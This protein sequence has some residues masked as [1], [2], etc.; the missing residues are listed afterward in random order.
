VK[1]LKLRIVGRLDS[2]TK[3][4]YENVNFVIKR[5]TN[6]ITSSTCYAFA[7]LLSCLKNLFLM[8]KRNMLIKLSAVFDMHIDS[9]K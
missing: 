9:T 6:E 5:A 2:Q 1:G 3:Y 7:A 4:V 8:K